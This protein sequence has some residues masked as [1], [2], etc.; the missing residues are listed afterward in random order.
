[1]YPLRC[2]QFLLGGYPLDE[3]LL[4]SGS[5]NV[6][7]CQR[8]GDGLIVHR[9]RVPYANVR[10]IEGSLE[11][12]DLAA[13][14]E[15][16]HDLARTVTGKE[17]HNL[18][19]RSPYKQPRTGVQMWHLYCLFSLIVWV[20][21]HLRCKPAAGTRLAKIIC[22]LTGYRTRRSSFGRPPGMLTPFVAG[23]AQATT[24]ARRR[25]PAAIGRRFGS[26]QSAASAAAPTPSSSRS[27][28][29]LR[30]EWVAGTGCHIENIG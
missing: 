27:R 19:H 16:G 8:L 6:I 1:M 4:G 23:Q 30:R 28:Y 17:V 25:E 20:A 7:F 10:T 12:D 29:S 26:S 24:A 13:S 22:L 5:N 18:R 14:C 9:L 15:F 21:P 11:G 2:L 3:T